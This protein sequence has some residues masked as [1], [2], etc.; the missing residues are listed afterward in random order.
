MVIALQNFVISKRLV[1]KFFHVCDFD[2]SVTFLPCST[3]S[4]PSL[5]V[6]KSLHKILV[7]MLGLLPHI[8]F[9]RIIVSTHSVLGY[10]VLLSVIDPLLNCILLQTIDVLVFQWAGVY[11]FDAFIVIFNLWSLHSHSGFFSSGSQSSLV[12]RHH[13]VEFIHFHTNWVVLFS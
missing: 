9:R 3:L 11:N 5:T 6:S 8:I 7:E 2:C 4:R 1:V 13:V 10:Y 12:D